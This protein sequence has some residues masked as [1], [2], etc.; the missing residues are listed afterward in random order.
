MTW[1]DELN[2]ANA[3]FD[4]RTVDPHATP[5]QQQLIADIVQEALGSIQEPSFEQIVR[6]AYLR[7]HRMRELLREA[8]EFITG[9]C[10]TGGEVRPGNEA[11]LLVQRTK[12][13]LGE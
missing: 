7:E 2:A 1:N 13:H 10:A 11:Y 8:L 12:A 4:Y 3:G 9:F 5:D 6:F